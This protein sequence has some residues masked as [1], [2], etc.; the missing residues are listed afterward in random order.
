MKATIKL[1]EKLKKTALTGSVLSI[2]LVGLGAAPVSASSW[3]NSGSNWSGNNWSD[4]NWSN[5]NWSNWNNRGFSSSD[6][7]FMRDCDDDMNTWS[8]TWNN[9]W[10]W[11]KKFDHKIRCDVERRVHDDLVSRFGADCFNRWNW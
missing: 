5:N 11:R 2:G 6:F 9:N 10:D 4:G 3:N 7:R 1:R 8:S